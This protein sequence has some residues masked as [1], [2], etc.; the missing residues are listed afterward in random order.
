MAE[1]T[2]E[3][4]TRLRTRTAILDAA[5][6]VF[7][8]DRNASMSDLAVAA[9]VGRS[10][11]HRYFPERTDVVRAA[12]RHVMHQADAVTRRIDPASRPPLEALHRMIE[13]HLDFAP[14]VLWLSTE[15]LVQDDPALWEEYSATEA[16]VDG[17]FL[18][19]AELLHP[20]LPPA[21]I[22]RVMLALLYTAGEAE[23]DGVMTRHE[24]YTAIL[25]TLT[26][27]VLPGAPPRP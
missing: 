23:R 2:Q 17:L 18:R 16:A 24:T 20:G 10:T 4:A 14:A 19:A 11:L 13:A 1:T 12:A 25:T 7:S 22:K 5:I 26:D 3:S 9:G 27:G 21:W 6:Q 15:P 8:R